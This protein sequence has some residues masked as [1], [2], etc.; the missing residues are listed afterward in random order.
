MILQL[1]K[2]VYAGLRAWRVHKSATFR[3]SSNELTKKQ[4]DTTVFVQVWLYEQEK[5]MKEWAPNDER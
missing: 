2:T 5:V 1:V 3:I 4:E